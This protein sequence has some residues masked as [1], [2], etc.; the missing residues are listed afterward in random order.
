M[1][2]KFDSFF[3]FRPACNVNVNFF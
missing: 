1:G 2:M 3:Q